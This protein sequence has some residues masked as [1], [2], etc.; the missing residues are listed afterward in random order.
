MCQ[1]Q[2]SDGTNSQYRTVRIHSTGRYVPWYEWYVLVWYQTV[3][4]IVY[5]TVYQ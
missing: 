1:M 3:Y 4:L 5:Q 2:Q